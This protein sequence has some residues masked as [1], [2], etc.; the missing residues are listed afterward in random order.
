[1]PKTVLITGGCGFI[2]TNAADFYLKKGCKVVSFDNLSRAGAKENL[3][4]LKKQGGNLVFVKGDIRDEKKLLETFK[5]YKPDLVAHLAAQTTMVTSV[6]NPREDFE[7]NALGTFNVLEALRKSSPKA[8][9]LYSSCFD[10][11]TKAV[12]IDGIKK[13]N[14]IKERDKVLSINPKTGNI[15]IKPVEEVII[16][17]YRGPML[18]FKGKRYEFFV[19]PNHRILYQHDNDNRP[20]NFSFK[21]AS[22]MAKRFQFF[23]PKGKWRG[24]N[25]EYINLIEK[26]GNPD[27]IWNR[28]NLL[29]VM[30]T[31]DLF[32]LMGI[33]IGDG[34]L[35]LVVKKYPTR[36]GLSKVEYIEM[37]RNSSTGR[38]MSTEEIG[39][40]IG[41]KE[42]VISF[43]YGIF[44]DI[45][46]NDKC[47]EKVEDVLKSSGISYHAYKNEHNGQ[48]RI[49]FTSKILFNIFSQCGHDAK[50]KRIPAWMLEYSPK[51]LQYL[52]Q[53][54]LDS[55]GDGKVA[56]RT[57]SKSLVRDFIELC[58]KL[59]YDL[60]L[61]EGHAQGNIDGRKIEGD[62]YDFN[63]SRTPRLAF[64]KNTSWINYDGIVWC[65]KV[66]D[67]ENFLVERNG[68]FVFSGNTNKVYGEMLD[69]P[70]VEKK[71]RYDYKNIRGI[72]ENY[73]LDFCGPYGCSKGTGDQ[74]TID[75]ARIYGLN[76]VVF[77]QSGIYGPHQFGIEEQGWLAWFCNALLFDKPVTIFG[78]G[79]QVRDVLYIDDLLRA[80]DLAFKN[81]KKT[82][83]KAY[84]IGGGP[85]FSLSIWELFEIL[86][87]LSGKK[88]NYKF[89]PW[90]P[91]DQK[92]YIS[93]ISKA[94]KDFGWQPLASPEEGVKK[95][96]N[97]VSKNKVLIKK[98][99]VFKK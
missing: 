9:I 37:A 52:F 72:S 49:Y 46:E 89:G 29:S 96:Y 66:K 20:T 83:G 25:E 2:G 61:R 70:V 19:T 32:Y 15:E 4:W 35:N 3:K 11:K 97:W 34:S 80:F 65:L 42:E 54:L 53:G 78:D 94:K 22:E 28:K 13:H 68:K 8:T 69:I 16:Q 64:R 77:R 51:Y 33:Y 91:G 23:L 62:Y 45:P 47:R 87:K 86:E 57:T 73:P 98:A 88:F 6:T 44:F 76:T 79:K 1:M 71:E 17:H 58:T 31:E 7:I 27:L 30:R 38:F 36:T 14:E 59:S 85:N 67:N 75:Y 40:K 39:G 10:E 63:I 26:A 90:R 48:S 5:K 95:L 99:G 12:T 56:F 74:Y 92:I 50:E 18:Y 24:K 81:I 41:A 43:G 93:D 82:R 60:S 21:P 55:D 84:N